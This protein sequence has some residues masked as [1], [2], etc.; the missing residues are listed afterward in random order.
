MT[1]DDVQSWLDRYVSA[2]KSYD[3]LEIGA[4]FA[5][6][7]EY[8]YH[9]W[10]EPVRGHDAIVRS[11]LEPAGS[12]SGRDEPGTY[13]AR[14]EPYAVEGD[15]AAAV[16]WSEYHGADGSVRQR[17][18]NAF[19][20]RFDAACRCTSFTELFVLEPAPPPA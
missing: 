6:D 11:W 1:R 12:A 10:D 4:L 17:Y 18:R 2:W 14:Y 7:A 8:R 20:L 3:P 15:K 9:P 13:D 5:E 16:G 19:L